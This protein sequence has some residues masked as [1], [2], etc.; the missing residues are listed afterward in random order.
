MAFKIFD[1]LKGN[2]FEENKI[3]D[4]PVFTEED[5]LACFILMAF[6][7][8]VNSLF[9]QDGFEIQ[10]TSEERDTYVRTGKVPRHI[11]LKAQIF[12][13]TFITRIH[14]L[15]DKPQAQSSLP[16]YHQLPALEGNCLQKI[17]LCV[18]D[19]PRTIQEVPYHCLFRYVPFNQEIENRYSHE[20]VSLN[21]QMVWNFKYAAEGVTPRKHITA[22]YDAVLPLS[23]HMT[24]T[25]G[26]LTEKMTLFCI[27]A[28]NQDSQWLRYREFSRMLCQK[29]GMTDSFHHV[30]IKTTK[31]PKHLGGERILNYGL[32]EKWFYGKAVVVFDDILT[33]G[34]SLG[35]AKRMLQ[36]AGAKVV[37]AYFLGHTVKKDEEI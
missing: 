8:K 2:I 12:H 9:S 7:E 21:R 4:K 6:T 31:K 1:F 20:Q 33:T 26:E 23:R 18:K 3:T 25:F 5:R 19:W 22:L 16:N 24:E 34:K 13:K 37:A 14:E 30:N 35:E 10:I 15:L 36:D 27:P 29:T 32:D 28:S 17:E 11:A